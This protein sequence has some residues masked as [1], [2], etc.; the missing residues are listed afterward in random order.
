MKKKKK[1][2]AFDR[3][4]DGEILWVKTH[5]HISCCDCGLAHFVTVEEEVKRKRNNISQLKT[6]DGWL[7]LR[8]FRDG[9]GTN[10]N[11]KEERFIKK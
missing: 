8:F 5:A 11:R 9:A 6:N 2:Q 1:K 4:D 3:L 10:R 7:A